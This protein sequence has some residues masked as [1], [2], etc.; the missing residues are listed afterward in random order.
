MHQNAPKGGKGGNMPLVCDRYF[1]RIIDLKVLSTHVPTVHSC[2]YN[3][4]MPPSSVVVH[5]GKDH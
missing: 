1:H 5:I 2:T 3:K 4:D